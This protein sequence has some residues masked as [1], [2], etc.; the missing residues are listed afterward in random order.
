MP[1]S[2]HNDS[3]FLF[4]PLSHADHSSLPSVSPFL[5]SPRQAPSSSSSVCCLKP[6][7][8]IHTKQDGRLDAFLLAI[9]SAF[10]FL[11]FASSSFVFLS[12]SLSRSIYSSLFSFPSVLHT[13]LHLSLCP[14]ISLY[15][16]RFLPG[17]ILPFLLL[18]F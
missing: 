12:Y 5:T 17:P 15:G 9:L 11:S 2:C 8:E 16:P 18:D 7:N 1:S 13:F 4:P 3:N 10:V 6:S 14:L